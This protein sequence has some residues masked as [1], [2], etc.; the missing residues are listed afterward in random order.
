MFHM[1]HI[2]CH[3]SHVTSHMSQVTCHVSLFFFLQHGGVSWLSVC[4]Q[5]GL[6]SLFF[7]PPPK[8][9]L[10]QLTRNGDRLS[11][12]KAARKIGY[13]EVSKLGSHVATKEWSCRYQDKCVV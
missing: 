2:M 13:K 6:P 5:W 3:M 1:S 8:G 10:Y 7:L 4:Y 12:S 9:F 11:A